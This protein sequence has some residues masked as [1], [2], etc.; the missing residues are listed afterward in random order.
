MIIVIALKLSSCLK[1]KLLTVYPG[2]ANTLE[3]E[4]TKDREA[5][6]IAVQQ[7]DNVDTSLT[8]THT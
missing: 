6:D 7:V 5:N 2:N 3:E 1:R 4:Q 8:T